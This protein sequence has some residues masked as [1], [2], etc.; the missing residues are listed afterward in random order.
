MKTPS[1]YAYYMKRHP[2]EFTP[3]RVRERVRGSIEYAKSVSKPKPNESGEIRNY[4]GAKGVYEALRGLRMTALEV[5][6]QQ[7][8]SP[9]EKQRLILQLRKGGASAYSAVSPDFADMKYEKGHFTSL[10]DAYGALMEGT[11]DLM[12]E[13]D[14]TNPVRREQV[15]RLVAKLVDRDTQFAGATAGIISLI[16]AGIFFSYSS[17][18]GNAIAGVSSS[19]GNWIGA[20]FLLLAIVGAFFFFRGRN[21][22]VVKKKASSKKK[23]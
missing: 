1:E 16:G 5:E 12:E 18:T 23:K 9:K 4:K 13:T 22:K 15:S 6:K 19:T 11:E 21:K 3:S 8:L 17:I 20:V 14:T 10:K 7:D 2:E